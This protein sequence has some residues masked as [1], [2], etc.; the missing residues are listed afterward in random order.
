HDA[1]RWERGFT[2]LAYLSDLTIDQLPRRLKIAE[3]ELPFFGAPRGIRNF[4][5]FYRKTLNGYREKLIKAR[6]GL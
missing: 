1:A 6:R 5:E 3:I 2:E 4:M